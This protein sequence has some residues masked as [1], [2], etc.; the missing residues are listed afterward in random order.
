VT[1]HFRGYLGER[2]VEPEI[3][4]RFIDRLRS[5]HWAWPSTDPPLSC[6]LLCIIIVGYIGGSRV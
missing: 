1:V 5:V 6:I 2:V 4:T 3:T